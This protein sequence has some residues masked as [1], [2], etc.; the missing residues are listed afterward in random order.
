[1]RE[2]PALT[3]IG[4]TSASPVPQTN[5]TATLGQDAFLRLLVAQ[6]RHQDPLDPLSDN[7]FLGQ[8]AQFSTLE[9]VTNVGQTLERLAFATQVAQAL[10]LVGR[11][12][13]FERPDG[14]L[15]RGAVESVSFQNGAIL[16]S[17]GGEREAITPDAVRSVA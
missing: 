11:T 5:P 3:G 1:M 6:L 13:T 17:I 9:Q 12:V 10:G 2:A 15:G 14:T 4:E 7:E 8:M 16:L